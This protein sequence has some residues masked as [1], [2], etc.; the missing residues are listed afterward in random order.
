MFNNHVF[1]LLKR[2]GDRI[3]PIKYQGM[4]VVLHDGYHN[5]SVTIPPF[6]NHASRILF[7][8]ASGWSQCA[9]MLS[10]PLLY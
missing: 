9:K 4:W 7:G 5:W 2:Q 10:A 3:V 6:S 1:E 8:G